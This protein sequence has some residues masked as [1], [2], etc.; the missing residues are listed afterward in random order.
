M[1]SLGKD[2][3]LKEVRTV[4]RVVAGWKEHFKKSGVASADIDLY[5]EQIDRAFLRDQREEFTAGPRGRA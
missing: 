4:A 2:E 3:A 5:A 1:F